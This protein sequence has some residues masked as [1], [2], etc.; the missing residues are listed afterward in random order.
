MKQLSLLLLI[1]LAGCTSTPPVE[2]Y[3]PAMQ[4]ATADALAIVDGEGGSVV[5]VIDDEPEPTPPPKAYSPPPIDP[6]PPVIPPPQVPATP[7]AWHRYVCGTP[8]CKHVG[9]MDI[10]RGD[11]VPPTSDCRQCGGKDTM[12]NVPN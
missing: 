5:F 11:P 1:C 6:A 3:A 12:V 10:K 9:W 7:T 8:G 2:D 4:A